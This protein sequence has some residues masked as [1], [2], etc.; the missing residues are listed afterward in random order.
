[1]TQAYQ[2]IQNG[3][4]LVK[5]DEYTIREKIEELLEEKTGVFVSLQEFTDDGEYEFYLHSEASDDMT[6]AEWDT[7]T[8]NYGLGRDDKSDE[9]AI[10]QLLAITIH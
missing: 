8:Q 1:M 5:G 4:P 3:V 7:L 6:D 9:I 10:R 2:L